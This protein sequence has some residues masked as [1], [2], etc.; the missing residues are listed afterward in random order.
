M[1]KYFV[2]SIKNPTLTITNRG[3][4]PIQSYNASIYLIT[5][6]TSFINNLEIFSYQTM[7]SGL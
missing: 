1:V 2:L 7:K 4:E 5:L 6:L 3:K